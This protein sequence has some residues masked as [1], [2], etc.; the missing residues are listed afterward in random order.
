M[1]QTWSSCLGLFGSNWVTIAWPEED[2]PDDNGL[3]MRAHRA[4]WQAG[5]LQPGV[6]RDQGGG[7]STNWARYCPTAEDCRSR[8]TSPDDNGVVS[9]LTGAVRGV[10]LTVKHTPDVSR[11]DR[12]HTDVI[13]D[14]KA[15]GVRVKLLKI[16]AVHL[17]P[18]ER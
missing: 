11:N 17:L 8:A 12:S 1:I 7:M 13:G 4:F 10:P 2:I 18:A 5:E 15:A 14:K 16:V 9:M 3:F 6:F